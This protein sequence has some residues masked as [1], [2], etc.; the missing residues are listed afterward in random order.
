MRPHANINA[1]METRT[2]LHSHTHYFLR[3]K[4]A[5]RHVGVGLTRRIGLNREKGEIKDDSDT[6]VS[7]TCRRERPARDEK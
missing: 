7:V 4:K 6:S 2:H 3:R 1:I 5:D